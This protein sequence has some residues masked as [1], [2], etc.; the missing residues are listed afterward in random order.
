M[1]VEV[2]ESKTGLIKKAFIGITNLKE[3]PPK[4]E[5]WN[6]NWR[7][8]IKTEGA[9]VYKLSLLE[10][11]AKVEGLL[12]LTLMFDEMIYMNDIEVAPHNYGKDGKHD[13]VAGCLIAFSCKESFEKGRNDYRGFLSFD[14]KTQ[15]IDFYVK[16]YG[17]TVARGSK[18]YIGPKEGRKLIDEYLKII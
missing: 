8:L 10:T 15:L 5:G 17:A 9:V 12:M 11:P 6:F 4:K 1:E 7:K 16:K 2:I 3:I 18:M 14:S 13:N